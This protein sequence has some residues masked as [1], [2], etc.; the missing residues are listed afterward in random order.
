[1]FVSVV[2]CCLCCCVISV[3]DVSDDVSV[4]TSRRGG[5]DEK[6]KETQEEEMRRMRRHRKRRIR[7]SGGYNT[8]TITKLSTHLPPQKKEEYRQ[9]I[10]P[11]SD[12]NVRLTKEYFQLSHR[13]NRIFR[14]NVMKQ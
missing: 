9:N 1:M 2:F 12:H 4:G 5:G 3:I 7:G 10:K 8:I 6:E 11:D 14:S 13:H